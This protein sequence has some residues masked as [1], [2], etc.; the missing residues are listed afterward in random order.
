MDENFPEDLRPDRCGIVAAFNGDDHGSVVL[1]LTPEHPDALAAPPGSELLEALLTGFD[2][3]CIV[4]GEDR[5][6]I[7]REAESG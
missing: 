4:C 2:P 1:H 5:M 7:R 6:V 3:V